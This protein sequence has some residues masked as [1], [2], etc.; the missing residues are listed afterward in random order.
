MACWLYQ[1]NAD[2]WSHERY[3]V[4][5]W[6]GHLV[7]NW[8]I[9]EGPR[10]P[11]EVSPGDMVIIF[12]VKSGTHD[13]GIYG[14]GIITSFYKEFIDF[15]PAPP[16]DYLKMNPVPEKEVSGIISKIRGGMA[17]MAM[18]KVEDKEFRE[19]RQQIAE[20]VYGIAP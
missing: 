15:R 7:T 20:H 16:S 12:F 19:L 5:V 14:W 18:F 9:G 3:R 10:K 17:Q 8:T 11:K 13:P 4:E 2:N 1:I 6:E